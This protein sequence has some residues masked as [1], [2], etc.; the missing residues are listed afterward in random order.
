M[1]INII[2]LFLIIFFNIKSADPKEKETYLQFQELLE[3][4]R[5]QKDNKY[6]LYLDSAFDFKTFKESYDYKKMSLYL[7]AKQS[8]ERWN[9]LPKFEIMHEYYLTNSSGQKCG[10]KIKSNKL[11]SRKTVNELSN[12]IKYHDKFCAVRLELIKRTI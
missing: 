4:I 7:L 5:K 3:E 2:Y 8:L 10:C 11:L 1:K 9:D 12:M 6:Q